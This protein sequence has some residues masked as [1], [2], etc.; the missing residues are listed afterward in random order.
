VDT[1]GIAAREGLGG[2]YQVVLLVEDHEGYQNLCSLLTRAIFEGLHHRPRVDLALLRAH[3]RGL[4]CLTSGENGVIRRAGGSEE[5]LAP[6]A[7]L[8]GPEHI[9]CE[10]M[11]QGLE[12]QPGHNAEVRRVAAVHGLRTVV[13]NDVRYLKPKDAVSLDLLNCI[14]MGA[15]INDPKGAWTSRKCASTAAR[16]AKRGGEWLR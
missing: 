7:E 16:L 6:L 14:A 10:L 2:A 13:T 8:F 1:R 12:W 11:D 4:I 9:F 15:S 5:R 3:H